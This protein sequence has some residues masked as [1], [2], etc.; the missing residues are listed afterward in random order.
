ML[1]IFALERHIVSQMQAHQVPGLALALVEG[2]EILYARGFGV[3]SVEEGGVSV[4]PQTLFRIGSVTKQFTATAIL[5]LVD[6]GKMS[7]QDE[8]TRFIPDYPTQGKKITVEQLLH[9]ARVVMD[10]GINCHTNWIIGYPGETA[11]TLSETAELVLRMKPTTAGF[12]VLTPYPGTRVYED[13]KRDGTLE[14][15]WSTSS[16]TTTRCS[17]RSSRA[18]TST[19]PTSRSWP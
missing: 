12:T 9:A 18:C 2:E 14:G 13:A 8:I 11:R 3:T 1:N 4:T 10:E 7:L 17:R 15:D 19:A 5:Q 6:E 16:S